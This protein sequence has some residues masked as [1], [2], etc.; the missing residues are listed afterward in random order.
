MNTRQLDAFRAVARVGT[1]TEAANSLHASQPAVSRLLAR[2]ESQLNLALFHRTH[3]RLQL[4]QEGQAL[5]REVERHYVG[6]DEIQLAAQRIA[7]HGTNSLR[8]IA[9]PSL[10]SELLP[11]A[12]ARYLQMH[13][14]TAVTLDTETTDRIAGC[15]ESGAYDVGFTAGAMGSRRAV[16]TRSMTSR[17]WLCAFSQGHLLVDHQQ[18]NIKQL[19]REPLIG[20]S[21]GMSLRGHIDR[22]FA[23]HSIQPN[24]ALSAQTIESICALVQAGCGSAILH[25]YA[26]HVADI[27]QL[28]TRP[29]DDPDRLELVAVTP[30]LP[31]QQVD[32]FVAIVDQLCN[33]TADSAC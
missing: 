1:V 26:A 5:L 7:E 24:F 20:F 23:S 19:S 21:A 12:I 18:I 2:L 30:H 8:I 10:S 16:T 17:P 28:V 6:L 22:I 11:R 14:D 27:R 25:P 33:G 29:L 32:E 13:P 31:L 3:G 9:F 4:T 15:V